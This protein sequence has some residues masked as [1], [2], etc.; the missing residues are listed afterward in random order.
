MKE[1]NPPVA[2]IWRFPE[3]INLSRTPM[4]SPVVPHFGFE[5]NHRAYGTQVSTVEVW[6]KM[7]GD[8]RL[9]RPSPR[10]ECGSLPDNLISRGAA[11]GNRTPVV[12]VRSEVHKS[13]LPRLR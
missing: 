4:L 7:A 5:P 1:S 13:A 10:L 12:F 9:E 6:H 11:G 3:V 2:L 8:G